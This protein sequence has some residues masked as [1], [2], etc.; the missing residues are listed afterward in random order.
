M[1]LGVPREG[2][3][4]ERLEVYRQAFDMLILNFACYRPLLQVRPAHTHTTGTGRVLGVRLGGS[5]REWAGET[6][7]ARARTLACNACVQH[8][9]ANRS[10]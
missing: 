10:L 9:P 6:D 7:R 2:P 3:S 1:L 4:R 8:M 5:S